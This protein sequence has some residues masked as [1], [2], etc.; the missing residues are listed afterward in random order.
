MPPQ[1]FLFSCQFTSVKFFSHPFSSD[2][3]FR[4]IMIDKA[5]GY[6][7]NHQ[8]SKKNNFLLVNFFWNF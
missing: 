3:G 6:V 4:F 8:V 1:N 7:L 2:V 5:S